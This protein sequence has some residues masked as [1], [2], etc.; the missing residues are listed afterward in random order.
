MFAMTLAAVS[1]AGIPLLVDFGKFYGFRATEA[2]GNTCFLY[3]WPWLSSAWSF[4]FT[5]ILNRPH[6]FPGKEKRMN[7]L[8][9]R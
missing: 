3:R 4:P 8:H 2:F 1:L 9:R 6:D 7:R 5:T